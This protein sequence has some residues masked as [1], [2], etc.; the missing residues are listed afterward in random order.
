MSQFE[1][2][3]MSKQ[4]EL[5]PEAQARNLIHTTARW[6]RKL[7]CLSVPPFSTE[8]DEISLSKVKTKAFQTSLACP[9]VQGISGSQVNCYVLPFEFSGFSDRL[10]LSSVT[11]RFQEDPLL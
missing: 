8:T 5:L 2:P 4:S 11:K 3:E 9:S 6:L 1:Q 10:R 7:T